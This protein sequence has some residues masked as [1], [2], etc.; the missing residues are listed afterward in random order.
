MDDFFELANGGTFG[1]ESVMGH[2]ETWESEFRFAVSLFC[3]SSLSFIDH[4][5]DTYMCTMSF[6]PQVFPH[7]QMANVVAFKGEGAPGILFHV[8]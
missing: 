6:P 4:A 3:A 7:L 8:P 1:S 5:L 2:W